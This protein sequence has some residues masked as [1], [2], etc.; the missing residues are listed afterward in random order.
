MIPKKFFLVT[1]CGSHRTDLGSFE[2]ALRDAGVERQ[3]FVSVS[4]IIPPG[5]RMID[6]EEGRSLL[7][8]GEITFCVMARNSSC[9]EG[10]NISAAL[11][12]VIPE[13][14][15]R[16]GYLFE[17][18]GNE[19]DPEEAKRRAIELAEDLCRDLYEC[20]LKIGA[21]G[22]SSEVRNWTT[23]LAIAIFIL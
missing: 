20:E 14:E 13:D 7:K 1:G 12:Y 15:E 3:N 16:N 22:I 4:S 19:K 2:I 11:S 8:P 21:V 17:Y 18:H 5:C 10:E 6:A 9:K 23:V